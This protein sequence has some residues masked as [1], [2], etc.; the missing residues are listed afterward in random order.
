M[1]LTVCTYVLLLLLV[2][3]VLLMALPI[4]KLLPLHGGLSIT[5]S[6]SP[7]SLS[8]E[9]NSIARTTQ[10]KI[11]TISTTSITSVTTNNS[12]IKFKHAYILYYSTT[13]SHPHRIII[14]VQHS[15][16]KWLFFSFFAFLFLPLLSHLPNNSGTKNLSSFGP[17]F[18]PFSLF[19]AVA[20]KCW[21]RSIWKFMYIR[22]VL[23]H[24]RSKTMFAWSDIWS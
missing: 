6:N 13:T 4:Q 7:I 21:E 20:T 22:N 9:R 3:M 19:N 12:N 1:V 18:C 5:F 23:Y 24:L 10:K 8:N 16:V 11:F 2:T 17:S 15:N 14:H